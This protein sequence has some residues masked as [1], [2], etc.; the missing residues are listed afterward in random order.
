M[1]RR[2]FFGC[3]S[4]ILVGSDWGGL[5]SF[6]FLAVEYPY[7]VS[8]L[9]IINAPFGSNFIIQHFE[10]PNDSSIREFILCPNVQETFNRMNNYAFLEQVFRRIT[11]E[12]IIRPEEMDLRKYDLEIPG[13]LTAI[14]NYCSVRVR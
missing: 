7:S 8:K 1:S 14:A 3:Q 9:I 5:I 4:V 12:D 13:S 6:L 10:F 2:Q 11:D